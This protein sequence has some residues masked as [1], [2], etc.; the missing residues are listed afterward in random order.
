VDAFDEERIDWA[1][2]AASGVRKDCAMMPT[3]MCPREP[4][5]RAAGRR[6]R[7][8]R[9]ASCMLEDEVREVVFDV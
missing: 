4:H 8:G 7:A 3:V 6:Q 5:A 9:S 2:R 1:Q